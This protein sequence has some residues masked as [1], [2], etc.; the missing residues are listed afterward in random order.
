[1]NEMVFIFGEGSTERIVLDKLGNFLGASNLPH[2]TLVGGKNA[3]G[4]KMIGELRPLFNPGRPGHYV[5]A[6]VFRDFDE[7]ET[8]DRILQS[9]SGIARNLIDAQAD[10]H[11]SEA[12][13]NIS[14]LDISPT[15]ERPGLRLVLHVATTPPVIAEDEQWALPV[16]MDK[17]TDGYLIRMAML[18]DVIERFAWDIRVD[19]KVIVKII[20]DELPELFDKRDTPIPF[21]CDKDYLFAYL[22]STRFWKVKRTEVKETL[23]GIILD[24]AMKHAENNFRTIMNSWLTAIAEVQK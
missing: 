14:L 4:N 10:W 15:E 2:P 8:D 17:T 19:S 7:G 1:M 3:F 9:F 22:V 18:P 24:R 16:F 20:I 6:L 13:P 23:V 11:V 5:R 12:C 21:D